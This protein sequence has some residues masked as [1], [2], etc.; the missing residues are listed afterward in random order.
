MLSQAVLDHLESKCGEAVMVRAVLE[1]ALP[2][3]EVDCVFE[4][5][6]Q[7]QYSRKLLFSTIVELLGMVVCRVRPSMH[8]AFQLGSEKIGASVR[9]VYDKLNRTEPRI[10]SALVHAAYQ[11][12]KLTIDRLGVARPALVRGY[13]TRIVDGNH[14][15]ATE[16]RLEPLRQMSGAPLPGVAIVVY[17]RERELIESVDLDEDAYTQERALVLGAL[18]RAQA[19]ELW[20]ADSHFCFT[21]FVWRLATVGAAY[22][23]RRHSANVPFK[24]VGPERRCGRTETGI[25]FER[26]IRISD[27]SGNEMPARWVRVA[28]N[29]PT[30]DGDHEIELLT[31]L[32]P[33]VSALQV[34]EAYRR[35]WDIEVA[36]A[37]VAQLFHGEIETLGHPRAALLAFALALIAYNAI[38]LV[39]SAMRATHGSQRIDEELSLYF[40]AHKVQ[41]HWEAL[42]IFAQPDDWSRRFASLSPLQLSRYLQHVAGQ[43]N[44]AHLKKHP[45][46]VK[47]PQPTRKFI[48]SQPHVSTARLLK[49]AT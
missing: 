41:S 18:D 27:G 23:V 39:K 3:L 2:P 46:G 34:A 45:R 7:R 30:R 22:L 11:R 37:D 32:P 8:A 25:V 14:L 1:N 33:R 16:H 47:K 49:H 6:R 20:I 40:V 19:K 36:F 12:M 42:D 10:S 28:L 21:V 9:A 29:Q 17:D 35:R 26:P 4:Q 5:H 44:L 15:A 38:S 13:H 43:V 24:F 48:K 31:N